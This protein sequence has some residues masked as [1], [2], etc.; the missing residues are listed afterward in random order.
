[1]SADGRLLAASDDAVEQEHRVVAIAGH[2]PEDANMKAQVDARAP[3][4]PESVNVR[5]DA[6][7]QGF[8][9]AEADLR[10]RVG[11]VEGAC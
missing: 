4:G 11:H 6:V 1:M 2:I 7:W 3:A 5:H 9:G 8:L 10:H